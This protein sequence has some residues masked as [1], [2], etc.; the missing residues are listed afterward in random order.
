M[1]RKKAQ[2]TEIAQDPTPQWPADAVERRSVDDLLRYERNSRIH[3][4]AQIKQL[5][6]S[7]KQWGW[8]MPILIDE[9]N[10]ILAGHG[11]VMAARELELTEVPVM[12]A[13]GWTEH[14]KRAYVI[15]DNKL[16]ENATWDE[17]LLTLELSEL[18]P[19][20][21]ITLTGF[22]Q[23]PQQAAAPKPPMFVSVFEVVI[24]CKD[25][26]DQR[27]IFEAMQKE[28]YECRVLSM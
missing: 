15:A 24:K 19:F 3:S 13:R 20:L 23:I 5:V 2:S 16:A 6:S 14:Q 9:Q 28:G 11:R 26:A 7:I 12:V 18:Q 22:D 1:A 8:T 17:E 27:K 4:P 25:E 21:D 10:M